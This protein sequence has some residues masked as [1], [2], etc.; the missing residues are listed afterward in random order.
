M[1]QRLGPRTRRCLSPAPSPLWKDKWIWVAF[2]QGS[3]SAATAAGTVRRC[4]HMCVIGGMYLKS[5]FVPSTGCSGGNWQNEFSFLP[6]KKQKQKT[7]NKKSQS[8]NSLLSNFYFSG[9]A[10]GRKSW[11][12][13]WSLLQIR[14]MSFYFPLTPAGSWTSPPTKYGICRLPQEGFQHLSPWPDPPALATH[15]PT[16]T[17]S[18]SWWQKDS[19]GCHFLICSSLPHILCDLLIFV[20]F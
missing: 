4:G 10:R 15:P 6:L 7:K 9:R 3:W 19:S 18:G 12:W 8:A 2:G 20:C 11:Q 16:S 5:W 17:I 13:A 14:E 1:P